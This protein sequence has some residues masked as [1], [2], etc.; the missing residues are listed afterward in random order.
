LRAGA[1]T[2]FFTAQHSTAQG[3]KEQ[4]RGKENRGRRSWS[5]EHQGEG[6]KQGIMLSLFPPLPL[7]GLLSLSLMRDT[8]EKRERR[9]GVGEKA[10]APGLSGEDRQGR[11]SFFCLLF[12]FPRAAAPIGRLAI[13]EGRKMNGGLVLRGGRLVREGF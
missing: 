2:C 8:Q 3:K 5:R 13:F 4:R 1:G 9:E 10:G 11:Q 6:H 12:L 7:L